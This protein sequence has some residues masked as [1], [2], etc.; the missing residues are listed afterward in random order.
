MTRDIIA[1]KLEDSLNEVKSTLV[2]NNFS[3][4]P[5]LNYEDHIVGLISKD[6]IV[7][8]MSSA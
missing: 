5:V 4:M 8:A 2:K 7:N 3:A 6:E 1:A